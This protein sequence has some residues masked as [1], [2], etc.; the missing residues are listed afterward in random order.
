MKLW[1]FV[2]SN[3]RKGQKNNFFTEMVSIFSDRGDE[4]GV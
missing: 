4:G 3:P 2:A 1:T